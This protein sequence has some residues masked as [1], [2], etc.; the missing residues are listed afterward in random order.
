[1][2][3]IMR[4]RARWMGA[5]LLLSLAACTG[6]ERNY[7][8]MSPYDADPV[9]T[10]IALTAERSGSADRAVRAWQRLQEN[11]GH[12]MADL[13][14]GRAYYDGRGVERDLGRSAQLFQAAYRKPWP[15]RGEA[16]YYLARQYDAGDGLPQDRARALALY[17]E[18]YASGAVLAALPLARAY[19]EGQG[20]PS[21]PAR[22]RELYERARA[23]G[24]PRAN[25]RLAQFALDDGASRAEVRE[26]AKPGVSWLRG[27]VK[28]ED[29]S[30]AAMQLATIYDKG[31]LAP[32]DR[33]LA[34]RYLRDAAKYGSAVANVKMAEREDAAGDTKRGLSFWRRAAEGGHAS[35]MVKVGFAALEDGKTAE[36]L[37]W[38]QKAAALGHPSAMVEIGRR[39]LTGD[40]VAMDRADAQVQLEKAAAMGHPS[41][42]YVLGRAYLDGAGLPKDRRK[43]RTWLTQADAA[44]HPAAKR[45]LAQL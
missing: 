44:G 7:Y 17:Q 23:L 30:W 9:N 1:M 13:Y 38:L 22:A 18:A 4:Q 5:G 42:M 19:D 28:D 21:D 45:A 20:V 24:D 43:A 31:E 16:A 32:A 3:A 36:G 10:R 27:L 35:G 12:P 40:G 14:L 29:N 37:E 34:D 41:A 33:E 26:L 6:G 11:T 2:R 25:L 8:E 15:R 39:E